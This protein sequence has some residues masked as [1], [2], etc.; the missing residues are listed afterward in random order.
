MKRPGR[1]PLG[2]DKRVLAKVYLVRSEIEAIDQARGD[3]MSRS[4]W[5]REAV[6]RAL[7]EG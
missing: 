5:I 1:P 6:L 3:D 2:A 7:E 4:D